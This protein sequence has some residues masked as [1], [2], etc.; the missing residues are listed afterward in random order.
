MIG[1]AGRVRGPRR[2]NV[3]PIGPHVERN[4]L[5]WFHEQ[6][7]ATVVDDI[8]GAVLLAVRK[9]DTGD[10]VFNPSAD[11]TLE[12]GLTLIVMA[13]HGGRSSVATRLEKVTG[14]SPTGS[15]Q[16]S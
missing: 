10:V 7:R 12:P 8:S 16:P 13:D 4:L 2:D 15:T 1:C 3:A 14:V 6:S 11:T 9:P 5:A